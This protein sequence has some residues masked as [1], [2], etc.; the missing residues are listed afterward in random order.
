MGSEEFDPG[1]AL[2][3]VPPQSAHRVHEY[4]IYFTTFDGFHELGVVGP[5]AAVGGAAVVV[6]E[7]ASDRQTVAD[8]EGVG[9]L[10]LALNAQFFAGLVLR[11][12]AVA[13]GVAE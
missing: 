7:A 9:V 13:H 4:D 8:G 11:D 5:R 3:A 12:A 6:G 10:A 2:S 1:R